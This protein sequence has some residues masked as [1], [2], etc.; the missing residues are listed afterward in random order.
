M[1]QRGDDQFGFGAP[2]PSR[3][4]L[5]EIDQDG[6][7]TS[8]KKQ[9]RQQKQQE[10]WEQM[11]NGGGSYNRKPLARFN[12]FSKQKYGNTR[13]QTSNGSW[14]SVIVALT[15]VSF[16]IYL[17]WA[18]LNGGLSG[19]LRSFNSSNE[20]N[21]SAF[22]NAF[23]DLERVNHELD[24]SVNKQDWEL[25]YDKNRLYLVDDIHLQVY[26]EYI[27]YV[28]TGDLTKDRAF[29]EFVSDWEL[30]SNHIP[31]YRLEDYL[32]PN[33]HYLRDIVPAGN[34]YFVFFKGTN[35]SYSKFDSVLDSPEYFNQIEGYTDMLKDEYDELQK[36]RIGTYGQS[37]GFKQLTEPSN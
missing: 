36:D 34:P 10:Q 18:S 23:Y 31:I 8:E 6:R 17:V 33:D 37:Q 11:Q 29:N 20:A 21:Q 15:V 2:Q 35:E 26:P 4:D 19:F 24:P 13:H 12:P 25:V 7:T 16:L 14:L 28:Y 9:E 1:N 27:I 5:L 3:R 32:I 22:M 30:D